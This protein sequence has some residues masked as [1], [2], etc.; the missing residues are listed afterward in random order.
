MK[1]RERMPGSAAISINGMASTEPHTRWVAVAIGSILAMLTLAVFWQVQYFDFVNYD[2]P[3]YVYENQHILD[4][5]SWNNVVWA[6]TTGYFGNW[7]PLT[8]LSYILDCQLWGP[9]PIGFHLTNLLLHLANTLLL[10]LVLRNMTGTL[11]RSAF[12]AALFA[13]HPLHVEPVAWVAGR[14]DVLSTFFWLLTMAAYTHYARRPRL[15]S[16]LLVVL[17]FVMG[18]MAKPMLVTL[19]FVLLLID[20]WPLNR[21]SRIEWPI[22]RDL[23]LEKV[24]LFALAVGFSTL[25]FFTQKDTGALAVHIDLRYRLY[26]A[27]IAYLDYISKTIWPS[28]LAPFYPH[29][30]EGISVWYAMASCVILLAATIL[31][32]RMAHLHRYLAV[33]WLWYLGTLVPVIGLV[34]VGRHAM[35]DRYTYIPLT[36]LFIIIAWGLPEFLAGWR[37]RRYALA[38][39]AVIALTALGVIAHRQASYWSDSVTL[40]SH[41]IEVTKDNY[42]AYYNRGTAYSNLGRWQEAI[43]DFGHAIKIRPD[44]ADP[45]NGRGI[46][47]DKL[48]RWQEAIEDLSRAIRIRP[49]YADAYI[50]RGVVYR[51]I[52]R[53]DEAI[54]DFTEAIRIRPDHARAHYSLA[55]VLRM[56]GRP[57]E[58][59]TH[60]Q[61]AIRIDRTIAGAHLDLGLLLLDKHR[62]SEAI[63]SL[64]E[65]IR[66]APDMAQAFVGMGRALSESGKP[67]EG[68]AAF[69]KGVEL[70]P[71]LSAAHFGLAAALAT[72]GD[73]RGA[74][75][76]YTR[77]LN[78]EP[79][80]VAWN[81]LGD[82]QEKL[83]DLAAARNSYAKAVAMQPDHPMVRYNLASVLSKMGRRDEAYMEVQKALTFDPNSADARKLL[84]TLTSPSETPK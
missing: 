41:A 77:S 7:N 16:Y 15:I 81:N 44:Y 6:F 38:T 5:L 4:G 58:A 36:G 69:R 66:L 65:A 20:Y 60:Y 82:A 17:A 19:P 8:W 79:D 73:Y 48:D 42:I 57:D 83:G 56:Q 27:F 72:R 67:E 24:P 52:G 78:I 29:L 14:K 28:H 34:Q 33:G 43:A 47:Y 39:S 45:Y 59:I 63:Q 62:Y 75:D 50:N 2:D 12:V 9:G 11:W 54:E 32:V 64:T 70:D 53:S 46:A 84:E 18:I 1:D 23:I 61:Q 49:Y 80:F 13:L 71:N 51:E 22:L 10:F 26:N 76:E 35:A 25:A 68:L 74:A 37:Y 30:L 40:F 21:I 31:V 3:G 55:G